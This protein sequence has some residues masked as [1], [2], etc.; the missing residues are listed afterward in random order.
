MGRKHRRTQSTVNHFP[1]SVYCSFRNSAMRPA[2]AR[3]ALIT[4]SL[5]TLCCSAG[6]DAGVTKAPRG[7]SGDRRGV[8]VAQD[9]VDSIVTSLSLEEKVGQ[10]VMVSA[11]AV[12]LNDSSVE[13]QRLQSLV[14]VYG[15]GGVALLHGTVLGAAATAN[16]LQSIARV[17]LLIAADLE[18]GLAM[19]YA[20]GTDF[21]SAMAFGATWDPE[22]AY[23][24]GRITSQEAR[25]VGVEMNFA[26]V[27][28]VN[29][30]PENPVINTRSYGG[31]ATLVSEMVAAFV[32]GTD[33]G[34]MLSTVKHF[35]GHGST[36]EDSHLVLP[37]V[38]RDRRTIDSL[39]LAPFRAAIA[40]GCQAVMVG[41]IAVPSI[42]PSELPSTLS[43]NIVTGVLRHE[44]D[45]QGLVISDAMGMGG[46]RVVPPDRAAVMAVKAGVDMLLLTTDEYLVLRAIRDAVHDGEISE[47]RIDSSVRRILTA[48]ERLG[49]P[50][51]REVPPELAAS[52]IA[53]PSH[54]KF[55]RHVASQS[56]TLIKNDGSLLPLPSSRRRI[57][58][59]ILTDSDESRSEV[60]RPGSFSFEEPTGTYFTQLLRHRHFDVSS[61]RLSPAST[62]EE[63]DRALA[64]LRRADLAIV[65]LFVG[66]H[67]SSGAIGLPGRLASFA[68]SANEVATPMILVDFGDPYAVTAWPAPR[69]IVCGYS[70]AEVEQEAVVSCLTG[71]EPI[72][73]RL[74]V[75]LSAQFP[76][77]FGIALESTRKGVGDTLVRA[78]ASSG[79]G[80]VDSLMTNAVHDSVFPGAQLLVLKNNAVVFDACFGR[81]TYDPSSP[82][83][84]DSTIF[85]LASLTKVIATTTATMRLYDKGLIDLDAPVGR[86][87]Q[88]FEQ[89]EKRRI[90]IRHLLLHRSGFPPFR[91]LWTLAASP[92]SALDTVYATPLVAAPGD[93]TIYSDFNMITLG[94]VIE[95]IARMPLDDYVR[96]AIFQP[97]GMTRTCFNPPPALQRSA[98]PTE[99]DSLWRKRQIQGT[100][101]DENAW[102]LGGV[103]GHAGLFSTASDLARFALMMMNAGRAY[104]HVFFSPA[105]RNQFLGR[106]AASGDRWLG[107][108]KKSPE[109]SSAGS[110]LSDESFGHTG[111]TG[112]S[113]WIDP[114]NHIAVV[115]LTNRV[116]PARGNLRILHFRPI[117]HDAIVRALLDASSDQKN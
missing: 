28:D 80:M 114:L 63:M 10:M 62:P 67:T 53:S 50:H 11:P 54:W 39:D 24:A 21:P 66:V 43:E 7:S 38:T 86:Y 16:H 60:N 69:A 68:R 23:E 27:A 30:N 103:S 108:D 85:D 25:A 8:R 95:H 41:H 9:W 51:V 17:P 35:P 20:R 55:A 81:Y 56:V 22:L 101:H 32:R 12:F 3:L 64:M 18:H 14:R 109:G 34:G 96:S 76:I 71:D 4:F 42:D 88:Q 82:P 31:D 78:I 40:S 61:V 93:S 117:I 37:V 52:R 36:R 107:W 105:T 13:M 83:V 84:K 111:F 110:L 65:S 74:P 46:V 89:G 77:G 99:Y 87:L 73:G 58:S 100:V 112:T 33:D 102:L 72:H 45:F 26:P 1:S 94:A 59:L 57:V 15:V 49:L 90:T 104:G 116:F 19:R 97:L 98:A 2:L 79:F 48:K 5:V 6:R 75:R 115:L 29:T 47:A 92:T 113:L 91:Q 44:M 106:T 70:D